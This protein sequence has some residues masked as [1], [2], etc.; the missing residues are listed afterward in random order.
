[1]RLGEK[2]E[3]FSR[4]EPIL[5]LFAIEVGRQDGFTVRAGEL[6]RSSAAAKANAKAGVGIK[7]SLHGNKL[8]ID[9][10]LISTKTGRLL[11][12]TKHHQR[13][14]AFWESLHPLCRWG[15]RFGDG[16]HYSITHGGRK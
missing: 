11:G 2:Q 5:R 14:G 7:L 3:L 9:Y 4:L 6:E 1:M 15:G 16:N 10:N 13:I 12:A 8:A